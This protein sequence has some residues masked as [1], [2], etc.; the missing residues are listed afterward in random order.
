M[1]RKHDRPLPREQSRAAPANGP[2][3]RWRGRLRRALNMQGYRAAMKPI[4]MPASATDEPVA[5]AENAV[6]SLTE[7]AERWRR[8]LARFYDAAGRALFETGAEVLLRLRAAFAHYAHG[9]ESAMR[10]PVTP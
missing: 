3:L 9:S 6:Q 2:G 10:Q 5:C 1:R 8:D 7:L 4:A